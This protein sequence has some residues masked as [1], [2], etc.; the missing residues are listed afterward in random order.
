MRVTGIKD[1]RCD[2]KL[3]TPKKYMAHNPRPNGIDKSKVGGIQGPDGDL[4]QSK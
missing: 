2:K 4:A 1:N 3:V